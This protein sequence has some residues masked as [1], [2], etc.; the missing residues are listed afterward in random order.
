VATD[1][2]EDQAS[3]QKPCL[4][5]TETEI[6]MSWSHTHDGKMCP[7][8]VCDRIDPQPDPLEVAAREERSERQKSAHC[9]RETEQ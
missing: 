4:I 9:N 5:L 8:L 1:Q 7:K 6:I 2:Q 3:F